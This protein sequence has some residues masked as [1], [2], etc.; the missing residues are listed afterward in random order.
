MNSV[1]VRALRWSEGTPLIPAKASTWVS[2]AVFGLRVQRHACQDVDVS[3]M[4]VAH[5]YQSRISVTQPP[6][7][8]TRA[9]LQCSDLRHPQLLLSECMSNAARLIVEQ[10]EPL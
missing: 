10:L 7:M 1:R 5:Q 2:L 4:L 6:G 8:V 3:V 9:V